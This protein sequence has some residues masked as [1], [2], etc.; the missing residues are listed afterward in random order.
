MPGFGN[1]HRPPGQNGSD[2]HD[3]VAI[4]G[5]LVAAF[6]SADPI[7]EMTR[8]A[9]IQIAMRNYGRDALEMFEWGYWFFLHIAVFSI[10]RVA[11][12]LALA[13][14]ITA[15]GYRLALAI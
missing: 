9:F 11:T 13:A 12:K 6:L 3:A 7:F 5:G 2:P 8:D 14:I 15:V 1:Q 10:A 4:A